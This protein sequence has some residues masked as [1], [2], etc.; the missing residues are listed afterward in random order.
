MTIHCK[1]KADEWQRRHFNRWIDN[2][3]TLGFWITCQFF[4][5]RIVKVKEL[6]ELEAKFVIMRRVNNAKSVRKSKHPSDCIH[7][8]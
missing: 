6:N 7:A 2:L 8:L 3:Q 1:I 4:E 5:A